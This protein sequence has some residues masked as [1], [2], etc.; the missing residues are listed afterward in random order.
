MSVKTDASGNRLVQIDFEVPGTPEQVWHAIATGPGIS[1]WFVPTEV[2]EREGGALTFHLGPG[3]DSPGVVTAWEPPR[4]FAYEEPD[5]NPGAPP[6]ATELLV[7]AR[8]GGICVVRMVHSLF[9]SS[10]E[11]DDQLESFEEGWPPFL[12]ILR[13]VMIHFP[14]ERASSLRLMNTAEGTEPEAWAALT[15]ALGFS[16]AAQGERRQA[17][18]SAPPFAGI[19]EGRGGGK[20]EHQLLLRLDEPAPGLALLG[21]YAWDGKIHAA[22]SLYLFGDRAAAVAARDEPL[23]QSW[24]NEQ[25]APAVEVGKEAS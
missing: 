24:M 13:L 22:I 2:E 10:E 1:S 5:W 20:H 25:F 19:V 7:E 8:S 9:T 17:P 3:I 16:G 14:G 4:R 18:A 15:G 6:V 11:W 23:W 21:A 12:A